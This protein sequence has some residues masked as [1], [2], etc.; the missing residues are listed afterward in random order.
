V[1][2]NT[3]H[4]FGLQVPTACAITPNPAEHVAYQWLPWE[5]AAQRCFSPTNAKAIGQ[6]PQIVHDLLPKSPV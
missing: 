2:H 6:L 4:V 1:L 3:E 5:A